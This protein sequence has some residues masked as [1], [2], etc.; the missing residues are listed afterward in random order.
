MILGRLRENRNISLA[1]YYHSNGT[2]RCFSEKKRFPAPFPKNTLTKN[3]SK[4]RQRTCCLF[5]F[6][7]SLS[8]WGLGGAQP[9]AVA[10]ASLVLASTVCP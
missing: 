10:Q 5:C 3:K 7:N 2:L 4:Q 1:K 6:H 8:G 9:L